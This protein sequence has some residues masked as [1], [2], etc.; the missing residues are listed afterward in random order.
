MS[1][2]CIQCL[3]QMPKK[4]KGWEQTC[5]DCKSKTMIAFYKV[6]GHN[7]RMRI[8]IPGRKQVLDLSYNQWKSL[9]RAVKE[10]KNYGN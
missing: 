2:Y 6:S 9:Y 8:T 1:K 3:K 4:R 10:E 5:P 7:Y